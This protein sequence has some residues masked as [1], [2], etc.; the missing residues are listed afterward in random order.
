MSKGAGYSYPLVAK[1]AVSTTADIMQF[2][3]IPE[4]YVYDA[5]EQDLNAAL[6]L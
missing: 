2:V 6:V 3:P 5:F 4:Y 1:N